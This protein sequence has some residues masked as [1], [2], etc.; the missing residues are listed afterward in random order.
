MWDKGFLFQ[1]KN[2]LEDNFCREK[3]KYY[4]RVTKQVLKDK[5][6]QMETEAQESQ[7]NPN[8]SE[9][10]SQNSDWFNQNKKSVY[11]G[12]TI[13][14]AI[15]TTIGLYAS[16]AAIKAV[17]TTFGGIGLIAGGYL[18]YKEINKNKQ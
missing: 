18:L 17:L 7:Q 3:L 9:Q 11:T 10:F 12:V 6:E 4:E 8:Y 16:K 1:V 5:A 15:L 2:E 13:G 14:G